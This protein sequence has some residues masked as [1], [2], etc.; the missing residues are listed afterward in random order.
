[1]KVE[2]IGSVTGELKEAEE[3]TAKSHK[4]EAIVERVTVGANS[5]T[6]I[7]FLSGPLKDYI[8][9]ERTEIGKYPSCLISYQLLTQEQ[10]RR[11]VRERRYICRH[12]ESVQ[13][14]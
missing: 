5:T 8:R 9:F 2:P 7:R 10:R 6:W 3:S 12:Q 1:M 11:M 14:D 4:T 13:T